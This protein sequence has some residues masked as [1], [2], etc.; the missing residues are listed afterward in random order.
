MNDFLS[1]ILPTTNLAAVKQILYDV[2]KTG[3]QQNNPLFTHS[4]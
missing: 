4:S 2:K 1:I 3:K